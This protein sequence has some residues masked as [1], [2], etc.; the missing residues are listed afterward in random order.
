MGLNL[1]G[2]LLEKNRVRCRDPALK[3]LLRELAINNSGFC[4]I[5]SRLEV[6][7]IKDF[8]D[9]TVE[10]IPLDSLSPEAGAQFLQ[11][12]GVNGTFDELKEAVAEFDG[13]A[14]ALSLLG[15]YLAI[16]YQGDIRQRNKIARLTDEQKQG[17]HA[18]RVIESYEKWFEDKPELNILRIMGLFDRSADGGAIKAVKANPPIKGLT[19]ELNE[20]SDEKWQYALNNLR[21]AK[22]LI[23]VGQHKPDTLD[24]HPLIREHFG[25]KLNLNN[26]DAW[27]EAHGRLYEYYKSQVKEYPET[28]EEMMPL[29]TAVAHGCDAS[30]HQE[31]LNDVYYRRILRK[32]TH[33]ITYKLRAP[34]AALSAVSSFFD[35]LWGLPVDGLNDSS[36]AFVLGQAGFCLREL[37]RLAEAVQPMQ[38]FSLESAIALNDWNNASTN[39]D[40]LSQLYLIMGDLIQSLDL[41]D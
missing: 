22:L 37:G 39:A 20:L 41:A 10:K 29:L 28:I 6:D 17:S 14:L 35:S 5:T 34:G 11:Y 1:Y 40:N 33:F 38:I 13:H 23:K 15:R 9:K 27:K 36:K 4:I 32:A 31:V 19:S 8:V 12:L 18:R 24:C 3:C 2:I 16:V 30:R 7:D 21:E 25:E 26:P